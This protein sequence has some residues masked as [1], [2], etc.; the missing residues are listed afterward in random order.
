MLSMIGKPESEQRRHQVR[1]GGRPIKVVMVEAVV[2]HPPAV[3]AHLIGITPIRPLV[4]A[5]TLTPTSIF[6]CSFQNT[7]ILKHRTGLGGCLE[8]S[9]GLT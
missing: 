3:V 5:H 8:V 1:H 9:K 7:T 4:Q 2:D 6:Q